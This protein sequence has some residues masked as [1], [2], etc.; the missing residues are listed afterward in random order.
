MIP[1]VEKTVVRRLENATDVGWLPF[2][3]EKISLGCVAVFAVHSLEEAPGDEG[4][5]EIARGTGM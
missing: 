3:Q 2:V 5:E 1:V 4:V